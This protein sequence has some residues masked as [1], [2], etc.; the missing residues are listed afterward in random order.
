MAGKKKKLIGPTSDN[1]QLEAFSSEQVQ[2][3]LAWRRTELGFQLAKTTMICVTVVASIYFG[4]YKPIQISTG[5]VTVIT[6]ALSFVADL[7]LHVWLAWGVAASCGGWA[8]AERRL[9]MKERETKDRRLSDFERTL[10]PGRTSS[11]LDIS[12][13]REL[14]L[15]EQDV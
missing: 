9:R 13:M 4:I 8:L 15:E 12:G 7:K 14:P 6:Y 10:D 5:E 3:A 11:N 1:S 2:T